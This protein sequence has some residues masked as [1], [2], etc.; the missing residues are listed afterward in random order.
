[1]NP[2][3][4]LSPG[5]A[6]IHTNDRGR[7]E[8]AATGARGLRRRG[9]IA[10]SL[11]RTLIRS[12]VRSPAAPLPLPPPN[13]DQSTSELR[14]NLHCTAPP[15]PPRRAG[16]SRCH[17]Q[18]RTMKHRKRRGKALEENNT[19]TRRGAGPCPLHPIRYGLLFELAVLRRRRHRNR[20]AAE[21]IVPAAA[22][23]GGRGE[24]ARR[25][26]G[27]ALSSPLS[28]SLSFPLLR[29]PFRKYGVRGW[30]SV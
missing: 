5:A 28:L 8:R 2:S 18:T 9:R 13:E 7:T 30:C 14:Q 1:M 23:P 25:G 27:K 19:L 22:I 16:S 6:L 29:P 24:E 21:L 11:P 20:S 4:K 17:N 12:S 10:R 15:P 3:P 26:R